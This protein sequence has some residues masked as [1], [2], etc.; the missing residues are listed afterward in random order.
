MGNN[1]LNNIKKNTWYAIL[2]EPYPGNKYQYYIFKKGSFSSIVIGED[3]EIRKTKSIEKAFEESFIVTIEECPSK[4]KAL[5]KASDMYNKHLLEEELEAI[6]RKNKEKESD[7][8]YEMEQMKK[9]LSEAEEN[10]KYLLVRF[11]DLYKDKQN[12][13]SSIRACLY[14]CCSY[15]YVESGLEYKLVEPNELERKINPNKR[16]VSS[17]YY[18]EYDM[19]FNLETCLRDIESI[20]DEKY[21]KDVSEIIK[22][23]ED[24]NFGCFDKK[25]E[26]EVC[27]R[28]TIQQ[29]IKKYSRLLSLTERLSEFLIKYKKEDGKK[30]KY[31][32]SK[33]REEY[34]YDTHVTIEND[35]LI[36]TAIILCGN[37]LETLKGLDCKNDF[38][39]I[40]Q[41]NI[42]VE[43]VENNKVI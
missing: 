33:D 2:V 27:E 23:Y 19:K 14:D 7:M 42:P 36:N 5:I 11:E 43:V 35:D 31:F 10:R 3:G 39:A 40:V 25:Y 28:I 12:I 1:Q 15:R 16:K 41:P 17:P 34:Y 9:S 4:E 20:V 8:M 6:K 38:Y 13:I 26:R 18:K 37:L 22:L 32:Y 30:I 29:L 21:K 24:S